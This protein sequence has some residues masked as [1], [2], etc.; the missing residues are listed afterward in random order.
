[1][2]TSVARSRCRARSAV[3]SRCTKAR[4]STPWCCR[5]SPREPPINPKPTIPTGP[6]RHGLAVLRARAWRLGKES[7]VIGAQEP[8]RQLPTLLICWLAGNARS[9]RPSA[10]QSSVASGGQCSLAPPPQPQ[11]LGGPQPA[12]RRPHPG[13]IS[14]RQRTQLV[15]QP[16]GTPCPERVPPG[17]SG[18]R[19]P[20]PTAAT[21]GAAQAGKGRTKHGPA[22]L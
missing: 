3:A 21:G 1:M 19:G 17:N 18:G 10:T 9:P 16:A 6:C 8:S 4:T 13:A 12:P 11:P 5:S 15:D 22:L 14:P 2:P 20:T 7:G